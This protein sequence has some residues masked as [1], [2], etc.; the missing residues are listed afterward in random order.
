MKVVSDCSLIS[1]LLMVNDIVVYTTQK[2]C[3][4]FVVNYFDF[5]CI[6]CIKLKYLSNIREGK[7]NGGNPNIKALWSA[8][9]H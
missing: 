6:F 7:G 4:I 9:I 5:T 3:F 8:I 2:S 1:T